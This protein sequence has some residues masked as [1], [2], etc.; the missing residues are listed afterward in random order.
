MDTIVTC[1]EC[2]GTG[3]ITFDQLPQ[4]KKEQYESKA[5]EMKSKCRVC[6]KLLKTYSF[7]DVLQ[8]DGSNA[9]ICLKCLAKTDPDYKPYVI[10]DSSTYPDPDRIFDVPKDWSATEGGFGSG[11]RGHSAWMKD[12]EFGGNYKKCPLCNINT[13]FTDGKC[14]ICGNSFAGEKK[15]ANEYT[16][17]EF[18]YSWDCPKCG[19][20]DTAIVRGSDLDPLSKQI[21]Q[22]YISSHGYTPEEAK[23]PVS[24][25]W[26]SH[27]ESSQLSGTPD[28]HMIQDWESKASEGR[29]LIFGGKDNS[30]FEVKET[31]DDLELAKAIAND[32]SA[33]EIT[34]SQNY[35]IPERGE[36]KGKILDYNTSEVIY[37]AES[38]ANEMSDDEWMNKIEQ[39]AN[40]TGV[41]T[42]AVQNFLMSV[43]SNG[44][45]G[46]ALSNLDMDTGL[47]KWN[48]RTRNAIQK[49][50]VIYFDK[51]KKYDSPPTFEDKYPNTLW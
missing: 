27:M 19:Y 38:K 43:S 9:K 23:A 6:D 2:N 5:S 39:L 40:K 47:Y 3:K 17:P 36:L 28:E 37:S 7:R 4:W 18:A 13:N 8:S 32:A 21:E 11:K 16:E 34:V 29:Y 26:Q 25:I 46:N 51:V 14:E 12:I 24:E 22:H 31:T 44:S 30:Y 41:K 10:G 15:K 1:H 42:I 49:G 33:E 48:A 35:T 20:E 45:V 50:I